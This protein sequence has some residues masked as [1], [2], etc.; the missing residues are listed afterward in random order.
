[1]K[2]SKYSYNGYTIDYSIINKDEIYSQGLNTLF[3][4]SVAVFIRNNEITDFNNLV[5]INSIRN[6]TNTNALEDNHIRAA[7]QAFLYY[8]LN[9]AGTTNIILTE[10]DMYDYNVPV[11]IDF[12]TAYIMLGFISINDA[13][14]SGERVAFVLAS[15]SAKSFIKKVVETAVKNAN[16]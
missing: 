4:A 16:S 7:F 9:D 5:I 11:F 12:I 6:D 3:A 1:M 10:L 13:F 2:H 8:E 14:P 15:S